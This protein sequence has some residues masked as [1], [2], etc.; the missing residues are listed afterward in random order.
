MYEKIRCGGVV[1]LSILVLHHENARN[2]VQTDPSFPRF[3]QGS[4]SPEP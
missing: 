3:F 4:V 2:A 1:F